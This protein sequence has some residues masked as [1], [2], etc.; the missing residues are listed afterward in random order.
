MCGWG[1]IGGVLRVEKT[2]GERL[3][4]RSVERKVNGRKRGVSVREQLIFCC[5]NSSATLFMV[6]GV[7]E[8]ALCHRRGSLIGV[9]GSVPVQ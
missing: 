2:V 8:R 1:S 5:G 6:G 7:D 4:I 9:M 3:G